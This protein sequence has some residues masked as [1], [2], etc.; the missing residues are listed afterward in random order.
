MVGYYK[1]AGSISK[2]IIRLFL[3]KSTK[4]EAAC[5]L[6]YQSE[7]IKYQK[8]VA[9]DIPVAAVTIEFQDVRSFEIDKGRYF[10]P[11]EASTGKNV[12]L[13]GSEIAD[14]LFEKTD[15]VGKP[16]TIAGFKANVIGVFKKEG[17]GGISDNGMDE[18][19][20]VPYNFGKTFINMKNNFLNATVDDKSKTRSFD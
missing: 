15:P 20:V 2:T 1:K 11:F 16:I 12:V 13:I 17:K 4:T 5:F 14:K 18:E 10:S 9:K 3:R 6:A 8:N 19:T 7:Q